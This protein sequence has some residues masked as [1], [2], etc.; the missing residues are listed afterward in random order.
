M[1]KLTTLLIVALFI[2]FGTVES[3]AAVSNAAVL[4]LRIAAGARAG[5]MGEAYVAVA[6]DATATH[7]NPAG[8]G[9]YPLS[10]K[11]FEVKIPE[12]YR[13]LQR[14]ALFKNDVSESD[15]RHYDIWAISPKGLVKYSK[16]K[17][18]QGEIIEPGSEQTAEGILRQYVGLIGDSGD[19]KVQPLLEKLA[20]ANN[21][22]PRE[23]LD[24]LRN[25]VMSKASEKFKSKEE[26]ENTF[27]MLIKAYNECLID[28]EMIKKA[29]ELYQD[30]AKD[31]VLDESEAD[32]I[33][34]TLER[35]KSK[36]LPSE[37]TI[38]FEI[39]FEG[40]VSDIAAD[41]DYLWIASGANLFR[42]NGKNWQ[43]FGSKE[44][45]LANNISMIRLFNRKAYL[46]TDAGLAIYD[47]GAFT[48][49]GTSA[50]LPE[51]GIKGIAVARDNDAWILADNDLYHFD[52]T[53]WKNYIIYSDVLRQSDSTIYETMKIYGT[54]D[55]RS[56]YLTKYAEMNPVNPTPSTTEAPL[57]KKY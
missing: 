3:Y 50:G 48:F 28:W 25:E 40:E 13:P 9:N 6:D 51:K 47:N 33:L 36:I 34:F 10:S 11:W 31:S 30:G 29:F 38:P 14:I 18:E 39:N 52:G 5:G 46:A 45:L 1:R 19:S 35:A 54:T 49:Y 21:P 15:Y 17:W 53:S 8:L 7:W 32:K 26:L 55:E 12:E 22:Y 4:F 42:Y 56:K 16:G 57:Q 24:T 27:T 20:R 44:G 43:K 2:L 23:R 37:L 41:D